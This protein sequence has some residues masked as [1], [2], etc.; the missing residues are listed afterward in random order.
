MFVS[1]IQVRVRYGETDQMG[2]VY[3]GN[4]ASYFEIGRVEALRKLGYSYRGLEESG[5]MLPVFSYNVVYLKPAYYDDVLT[6][7]TTIKEVPSVRIR[8]EYEIINAKGEKVAEAE[9]TLV[10]ISSESKKPSRAP[11]GLV[12]RLAQEIGA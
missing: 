11:E 1:Q 7:R 5:I 12:E 10:F 9:T 4:Y 3:Y 2:Y 6:I 8:F